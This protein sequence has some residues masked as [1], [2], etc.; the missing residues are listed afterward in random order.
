MNSIVGPIFNEK[1][2]EKWSLWT[3]YWKIMKMYCLQEKSTLTAKKKKKRR[4]RLLHATILWV[5][6][7]KHKHWNA[8]NAETKWVHSIIS[9]AWC[10]IYFPLQE[11]CRTS[12]FYITQRHA[13]IVQNISPT[14]AW[15]W[16]PLISSYI[17][18]RL[19]RKRPI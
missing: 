7:P 12:S 17:S 10:I 15:G 14:N 2:T 11:T 4:T 19:R 1:I 3:V 18:I 16:D 13:R 6:C 5:P 8:V 9:W